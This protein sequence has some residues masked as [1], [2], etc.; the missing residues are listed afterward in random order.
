MTNLR[1]DIL[2]SSQKAKTVVMIKLI[3][4]WKDH[5]KEANGTFHDVNQNTANQ[6]TSCLLQ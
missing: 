6:E 3:V 5:I 2:L 4:P 1:P